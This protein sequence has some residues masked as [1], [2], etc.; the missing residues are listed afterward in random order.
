[1][2]TKNLRF[3]VRILVNKAYGI[4]GFSLARLACGKDV[5]VYKIILMNIME[6]GPFQ[7]SGPSWLRRNRFRPARPENTILQYETNNL[8]SQ[9]R[10]LGHNDWCLR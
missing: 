2:F 4:L 9:T 3:H 7:F 5:N 8:T 6:L 10:Y 1:M